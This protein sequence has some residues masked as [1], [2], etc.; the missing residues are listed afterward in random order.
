MWKVSQDTAMGVA[1]ILF[2]LMLLFR[3]QWFLAETTK[4]QRLVQRFGSATALWILR[5]CLFAVALLGGLLAVGIVKPIRWGR[6]VHEDSRS[7]GFNQVVQNLWLQ[8]N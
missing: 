2:C 6:T 8:P 4:G 1:M 5:G 7:G 3:E